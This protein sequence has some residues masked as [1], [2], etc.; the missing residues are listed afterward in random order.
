MGGVREKGV[1]DLAIALHGVS[2]EEEEEEKGRGSRSRVSKDLEPEKRKSSSLAPSPDD[3]YQFDPG[4]GDASVERA[5][6]RRDR[7]DES[8]A[9]EGRW[10]GGGEDDGCTVFRGKGETFD[11]GES[12][13]LVVSTLG[14]DLKGRARR[15]HEVSVE[16]YVETAEKVKSE[17]RQ[18]EQDLTYKEDNVSYDEKARGT[19]HGAEKGEESWRES[20][21]SKL[22][23]YED[24]RSLKKNR[25][26]SEDKQKDELCNS[27]SGKELERHE[28]RRKRSGDKDK[29]Q[30]DIWD[31]EDKHLYSHRYERSRDNKHKDE[32]YRDKYRDDIYR[33]HRNDRKRDEHS[34]RNQTSDRPSNK[35]YRDEHKHR[36][37]GGSYIENQRAKYRDDNRGRKRS[38]EEVR[39]Y[40]DLKDRNGKQIH[41]G[42]ENYKSDASFLYSHTDRARTDHLR[43]DKVDSSWHDNRQ[44]KSPRHSTLSIK[45]ESRRNSKQEE[46]LR[47]A[48]SMEDFSGLS[49]RRERASDS[50]S[51][52]KIKVKDDFTETATSS[53]YNRTP[54]S[55]D[56]S[57]PNMSTEKSP[58]SANGQR[59]LEKGGVNSEHVLVDQSKGHLL[60]PPPVRFGIENPS[61]LG[62][63]EE[64]NH[65]IQP[66]GDRK[67]GSRFKRN[68]GPYNNSWKTA[69]T[70]P[71]PIPNGFIPFEQGPPPPDFHST[72]HQ[73]PAPSLFGIRPPLE[74]SHTRV[75]YNMHEIAGQY[76]GHA[77]PFGW[78]NTVKDSYPPPDARPDWGKARHPID[79]P[80]VNDT[81]KGQN[82]KNTNIDFHQARANEHSLVQSLHRTRSGQSLS[83]STEIKRSSEASPLKSDAEAPS[84]NILDKSSQPLKRLED[85]NPPF[86]CSYLSKI[87]ISIDLTSSVLYKHCVTLLGG[88][89]PPD[90]S[91]AAKHEDLQ[92]TK[93][94]KKVGKS[95]NFILRS[96]FPEK[97]ERFFQRAMLISKMH[98]EFTKVKCPVSPSSE[99]SNK[100]QV[101]EQNNFSP[102]KMH[103]H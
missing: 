34:S 85:D 17:K 19:E 88:C 46:K 5:K 67:P 29:W 60:P 86:C 70:W 11:F 76:S 89:D 20:S 71:S 91:D 98:T 87:D 8:P 77:R 31:T 45:E 30:A 27:E 23:V 69:P 63:Y 24:E 48:A 52:E 37:D 57:T 79:T 21:K 83:A 35:H 103:R 7:A 22:R 73:Y 36:D 28:K 41:L 75:S 82:I 13:K 74:M 18:S 80:M 78:G 44:N 101:A 55:D 54:R 43:Q 14:D 62:S 25:E 102:K 53:K 51:V 92:N 97:K 9:I 90:V 64:D 40:S 58:S 6:K 99:A 4:N 61:V 15:R 49:G 26:I 42:A 96:L 95:S 39:V 33:V 72:I 12:E 59:L 68:S 38:Y 84:S 94:V 2:A 47:D 100:E 10:S 93:A 32:R 3:R 81:W 16:R 65:R 66:M 50:Q 56:C 1:S